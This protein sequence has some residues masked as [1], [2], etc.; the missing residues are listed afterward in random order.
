ML[1]GT[2]PNTGLRQSTFFHL[3]VSL[4]FGAAFFVIVKEK[5]GGP[6]IPATLCEPCL[7]GNVEGLKDVHMATSDLVS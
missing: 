1:C 4:D 2:S 7:H 5:V 3:A 6:T